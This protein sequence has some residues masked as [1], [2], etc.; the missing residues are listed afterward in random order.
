MIERAR[1]KHYFQFYE[2]VKN[3]TTF[4]FGN[5]IRGT[6]FAIDTPI[7]KAEWT[8]SNLAEYI[9]S[10]RTNLKMML[11]VHACE[12]TLRNICGEWKNFF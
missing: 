10:Q 4:E 6:D 2:N 7:P 8:S 1:E 3:G 9:E 5:P 12:S 11:E